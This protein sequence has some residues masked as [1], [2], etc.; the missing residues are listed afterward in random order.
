MILLLYVDDIIIIGNNPST[1]S[2]LITQLAKVFAL[3]DIS[4]LHYILGLEAYL[5]KDRLFL[6]QTKYVVDSWKKLKL[7]GAKQY[8]SLVDSGSKH[9]LLDGIHCLIHLNTAL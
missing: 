6:S 9:S 1:V 4:S 5:L 8:S 2:T 3:K 7:D